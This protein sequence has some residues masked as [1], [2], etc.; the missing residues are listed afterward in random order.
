MRWR[1]AG[2]GEA[3]SSR[4]NST[5]QKKTTKKPSPGFVYSHCFVFLYPKRSDS[6]EP[7]F[8]SFPLLFLRKHDLASG[9]ESPKSYFDSSWLKYLHCYGLFNIAHMWVI[10]IWSE[11]NPL[12]IKLTVFTHIDVS[13]CLYG[14]KWNE[15]FFRPHLIQQCMQPLTASLC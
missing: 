9:S 13:L 1:G 12:A 14:T 10:Q 6:R 3:S 4:W 11:I 5:W 15:L 2:Q 7:L 8:P